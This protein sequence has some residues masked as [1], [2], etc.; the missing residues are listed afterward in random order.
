MQTV[1]M[2]VIGVAGLLEVAAA[3]WMVRAL[4]AHQ[5]LDGRVAHLADALSLLT[6][7]TEAGF[8]A[9]AV[10]IGRLADA[11]PRAGAGSRVSANRR[12]AAARGRGISVEQIAASE[13]MSVGEVGLR[14]RLHEAAGSERKKAKAEHPKARRRPPTAAAVAQA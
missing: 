10:E 9:T 8:K 6:E 3:W 7:T 13:K 5:Q 2:W 12:L 14:L 11:A 4:R 1:A